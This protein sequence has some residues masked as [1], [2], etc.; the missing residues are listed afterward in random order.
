M[1]CAQDEQFFLLPECFFPLKAFHFWSYIF[2][3]GHLSKLSAVDLFVVRLKGNK[4]LDDK[5]ICI[6][7][8]PGPF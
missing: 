8:T 6:Q 2:L 3:P 1:S 4:L 7:F 5:Y